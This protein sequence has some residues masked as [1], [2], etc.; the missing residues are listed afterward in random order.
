MADQTGFPPELL[1]YVREVSLQEDEILR[2]LREETVT[3]PMGRT[4]Q[5]MPEEGQLLTLLVALTGARSVLEIGTFTGYSTLCMARSLPSGGRLV[6]C[7]ITARWPDIGRPYWKRAGVEDRIEVRI[8][9]ARRTLAG[10]VA[11]GGADTVDLVFI[12]ADKRNHPSYY[13]DALALVRPGG[14]IVLDNTVFFGRVTDP[15]ARD[16][17]TTAIRE[18][19]R[20]VHADDRVDLSMLPM[21]DGI[22]LIRKKTP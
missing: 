3:Y 19:N 17:D 20:R 9:D 7:D 6:T 18:L 14:L 5:V 4:L 2:E 16:P 10:L 22:S 13:E 11:D 8:D 21:A 1:A 12:D 15:E